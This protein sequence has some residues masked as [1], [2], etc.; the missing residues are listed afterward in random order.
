M[1]C[2]FED[3]LFD[4]FLEFSLDIFHEYEISECFFLFGEEMICLVYGYLEG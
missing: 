3:R 4:F 2:C 1:E